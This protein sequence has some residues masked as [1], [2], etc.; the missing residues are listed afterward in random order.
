MRDSKSNIAH[1]LLHR[2]ELFLLAVPHR[3]ASSRPDNQ[4][5]KDNHDLVL[6]TDND[7]FIL[8]PHDD[9]LFILLHSHHHIFIFVIFIFVFIFV[10]HFIAVLLLFIIDNNFARLNFHVHAAGRTRNRDPKAERLVN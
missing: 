2:L 5:S 7:I 6:Q 9:F 3:G 10:L 8:L 1:L 4:Q